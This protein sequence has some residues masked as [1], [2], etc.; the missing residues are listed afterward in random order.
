[1][2]HTRGLY[3]HILIQITIFVVVLFFVFALSGCLGSAADWLLPIVCVCACVGVVRS[4]GD[5]LL[6]VRGCD[7]D[8]CAAEHARLHRRGGASLFRATRGAWPDRL[9]TCLAA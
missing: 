3:I 6:H 5:L 1:M 4:G 2:P 7:N 8:V 9:Q